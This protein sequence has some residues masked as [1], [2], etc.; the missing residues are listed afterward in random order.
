MAIA[1]LLRQTSHE[2]ISNRANI[3]RPSDGLYNVLYICN[4]NDYFNCTL[5][6]MTGDGYLAS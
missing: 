5:A 6:H 1:S 3:I 4:I 2:H